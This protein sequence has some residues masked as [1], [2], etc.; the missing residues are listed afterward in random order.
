MVCSLVHKNPSHQPWR[1]YLD[2][3]PELHGQGSSHIH[4]NWSQ[5]RHVSLSWWKRSAKSLVGMH[6]WKVC[7]I[8]FMRSSG[9]SPSRSSSQDSLSQ[10]K[11]VKQEHWPSNWHAVLCWP[12]LSLIQG[13]RAVPFKVFAGVWNLRGSSS[14]ATGQELQRPRMPKPFVKIG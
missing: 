5:R 9:L 6:R 10:E 13:T 3:N 2:R 8:L 14:Y 4:V 11:F 7:S 1:A 12:T